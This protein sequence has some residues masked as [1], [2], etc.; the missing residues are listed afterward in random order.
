MHDFNFNSGE[1]TPFHYS[2][3]DKRFESYESPSD[4][5]N[6]LYSEFLSPPLQH[7]G[8]DSATSGFYIPH[9]KQ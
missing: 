1:S 5:M 6:R 4:N 8:S 2:N 3:L 7:A 9:F